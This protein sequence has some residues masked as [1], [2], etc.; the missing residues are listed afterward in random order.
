MA[1][2]SPCSCDDEGP[3]SN[4]KEPGPGNADPP[5]PKTEKPG[6]GT[7]GAPSSQ[8]T[9]EGATN[10]LPPPPTKKST[11][12]ESKPKPE[13][14]PASPKVA[15]QPAT[16]LQPVSSADSKRAPTSSQPR[17]LGPT[18]APS[19]LVKSVPPSE[20]TAEVPSSS[21]AQNTGPSPAPRTRLSSAKP[22]GSPNPTKAHNTTPLVGGD[23]SEKVSQG[24]PPDQV[25][26]NNKSNPGEATTAKDPSPPRVVELGPNENGAL[27]QSG[28]LGL[29]ARS[30]PRSCRSDIESL[31]ALSPPNM[32]GEIEPIDL[33]SDPDFE[34][35]ERMLLSHRGPQ[36]SQPVKE[37]PP[38]QP[39]ASFK[40]SRLLKR[41]RS[42]PSLPGSSQAPAQEPRAGSKPVK[43]PRV[44]GPSLN[45]RKKHE[46]FWD[47]DGT[48]VLQVENVIFRVMRSTLS[49]ASP[50]FRKMFNEN[51]DQLE[52]MAGCPVY[53]VEEDLSHLDLANLLCGLENGL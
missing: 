34:M 30:S 16:P 12:A 35:M 51:F 7:T 13:F 46:D 25:D 15:A 18:P 14:P 5:L 50:W 52:I 6:S 9:N 27:T 32:A 22:Q 45:D 10:S 24:G 19:V 8:V 43:R 49:K 47:L 38:S 28:D 33:E 42:H 39:L 26:V 1:C 21:K 36:S 20:A 23:A 4:C 37:E 11:K 41:Q 2:V 3:D 53:T 44:K 31:Y 29:P 17:T 48:V 40:N